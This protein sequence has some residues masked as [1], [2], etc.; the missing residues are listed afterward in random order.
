MESCIILLK[1]AAN[2]F[3]NITSET[4][5]REVLSSAQGYDFLCGIYLLHLK[6]F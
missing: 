3:T 5:L 2:I 1:M 4:V 6:N